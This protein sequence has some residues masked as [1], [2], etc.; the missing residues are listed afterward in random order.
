MEG[1]VTINRW[2]LFVSFKRNADI[3][4][5]PMFAHLKLI[6][7]SIDEQNYL[8]KMMTQ[9]GIKPPT[10]ARTVG[11]EMLD[12]IAFRKEWHKPN[13]FDFIAF[14]DAIIKWL[15]VSSV[16]LTGVVMA[17]FKLKKIGFYCL[18][19]VDSLVGL[20]RKFQ[21]RFEWMFVLW[22]TIYWFFQQLFGGDMFS[23]MANP[24]Q[25][26]VIDSWQASFFSLSQIFLHK[27]MRIIQ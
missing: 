18:V 9:V 22:I 3:A 11:I 24:D 26:K 16:I 15:F 20:E 14:I 17:S 27:I 8:N 7:F 4:I 1:V 10:E 2:S 12:C 19:V 6:R 13:P 23:A 25:A 21:S 5:V